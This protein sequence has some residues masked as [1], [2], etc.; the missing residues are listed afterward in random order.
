MKKIRLINFAIVNVAIIFL[1]CNSYA[2][3]NSYQYEAILSYSSTHWPDVETRVVSG[4]FNYYLA[5]VEYSNYPSSEN[6]FMARASSLTF[7]FGDSVSKFDSYINDLYSDRYGIGGR[8]FFDN[9]PLYV[10]VFYEG[11]DDE[12][13][14]SLSGGFI[15]PFLITYEASL[16][17]RTRF[18]VGGED[19]ELEGQRLWIKV[20]NF[21]A[22]G[23]GYRVV[24]FR[25]DEE[26]TEKSYKSRTQKV[27]YTYF[28]RTGFNLSASYEYID[29]TYGTNTNRALGVEWEYRPDIIFSVELGDMEE[30]RNFRLSIARGDQQGD[31]GSFGVTFRF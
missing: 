8:F 16:Y 22:N 24:V 13:Y 17:E 5:P 12:D 1:T 20:Q 15:T 2:S 10:K 4:D 30:D 31:F 23:D 19:L 29:A 6:A 9:T 21:F 14:R 11:G 27:R 25:E 18:V 28:I 3:D 26:T 7:T